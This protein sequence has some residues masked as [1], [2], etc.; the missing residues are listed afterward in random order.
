MAPFVRVLIQNDEGSYLLIREVKYKQL[1]FPG[2]KIKIEENETP[3][4]AAIREVNEE[5]NLDLYN[6]RP[7]H[8]QIVHFIRYP[9]KSSMGY[10][11]TAQ[12]DLS[13]L[14]VMEPEKLLS[15]GYFSKQ[16]IMKMI[17]KGALPDKLSESVKCAMDHLNPR[18]HVIGK[19]HSR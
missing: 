9:E 3:I 17:A 16:A 13:R 4:N 11:F 12:A 15:L 5:V 14:K 2:G 10:F 8:N 18:Q 19:D 7:L 1:N 6:V